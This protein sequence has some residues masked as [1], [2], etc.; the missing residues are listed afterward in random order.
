MVS[1]KRLAQMAKK[2][3]R[4]AAMA[5]RR[6]A[7]APTKGT[8]E[9]SSPCSTSPVAGKGHCVVYSADGRRFEVPLA[10]LDTA[11]FGV[12]LSM[13]QEEFGFASD[14]GRIMVPCDAAVMEYVM[15]LLRRDASE[16][17]V[18]AFLS[19]MVRPCHCGNGLVQSMGVSQ[20]AVF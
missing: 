15:C 11:I 13:S 19:S 6:I 4:M 2:W 12:L 18:R 3:Q 14:D 5:R 17:V 9:G 7:S 16:E 8:T 20:Q 10:Y 1:A